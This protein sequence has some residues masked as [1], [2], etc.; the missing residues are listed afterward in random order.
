MMEC[1]LIPGCI[2]CSSSSGEEFCVVASV[3]ENFPLTESSS[4]GTSC[5]LL[6][7][8]SSLVFEEEQ[9][10]TSIQAFLKTGLPYLFPFLESN[11][12][13]GKKHTSFLGGLLYI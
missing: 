12:T 11:L 6:F 13:V 8:T 10:Q 7:S 9:N 2:K 4:F 5:F 3:A 1:M